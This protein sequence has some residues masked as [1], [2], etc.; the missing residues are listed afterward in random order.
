MRYCL[1]EC[2]R[3]PRLSVRE[4]LAYPCAHQHRVNVPTAAP[5]TQDRERFSRRCSSRSKHD[6]R[7]S[8]DSNTRVQIQQRCHGCVVR[9]QE[10]SSIHTRALPQSLWQ[11]ESC[12]CLQYKAW[13]MTFK[14]SSFGFASRPFL[15]VHNSFWD[16]TVYFWDL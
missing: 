7:Y 16:R 15:T 10:Y 3:S 12:A 11:L 2:A 9:R 14:H 1:S 13:L 5:V 6:H 4:Y 8:L